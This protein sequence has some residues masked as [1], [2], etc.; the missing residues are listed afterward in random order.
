MINIC[1]QKV[2]LLNISLVCFC[3]SM[4]LQNGLASQCICRMLSFID[5]F[6]ILLLSMI[7]QNLLFW[8]QT[9][10]STSG[11]TVTVDANCC[12]NGVQISCPQQCVPDFP[13]L[14]KPAMRTHWMAGA[15]PHKAGNVETNPG[16]TNTHKQVWICDIC[17]KQIHVR[18]QISMRCNKIGCT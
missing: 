15:A 10:H 9:T 5:M 1:L 7:L 2:L 17:H 3:L 11:G 8:L 4:C 6:I 18:K 12:A 16:P 14:G 13:F